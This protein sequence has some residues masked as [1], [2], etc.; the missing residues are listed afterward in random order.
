MSTKNKK[1]KILYASAAVSAGVAL[2]LGTYA[3]SIHENK[4]QKHESQ[5]ESTF[6]ELL[7]KKSEIERLIQEFGTENVSDDFLKLYDDI[8]N[9]LESGAVSVDDVFD[10]VNRSEYLIGFEKVKF[11]INNDNP[12]DQAVENLKELFSEPSIKKSAS[13]LIDNY[14]EQIKN[15]QTKEEKNAL[16]D[17][18]KNKLEGLYNEQ[19]L[20]DSNLKKT[21]IRANNILNDKNLAIS[22]DLRNQINSLIDNIN[23]SNNLDANTSEILANRLN[24]LIDKAIVENNKNILEDEK[25]HNKANLALENLKTQNL[26]QST[27]DKIAQQINDLLN[28]TNKAPSD[29]NYFLDYDL[30]NKKLDSII[31][32][33]TEYDKPISELK[34]QLDANLNNLF[35]FKKNEDALKNK[36]NQLVEELSLKSYD[37]KDELIQANNKL[38]DAKNKVLALRNEFEKTNEY[39]DGLIK[40]GVVPNDFKQELEQL[41]NSLSPEES[42]ILNLD[43]TVNKLEEKLAKFKANLS[44]QA[45]LKGE[46]NDSIKDIDDLIQNGFNVDSEVANALKQKL[47]ELKQISPKNEDEYKEMFDKFNQLSNEL[48]DLHKKE[49]ADLVNENKKYINKDYLDEETRKRLNSLIM[50]SEPLANPESSAVLSQI[51]PKEELLREL[52]KNNQKFENRFE[53]GNNIDGL[54]NDSIDKFDNSKIDGDIKNNVDKFFNDLKEQVNSINEN[55]KLTNDQKL[56][57][58]KELMDKAEKA[59]ENAEKLQDYTKIAKDSIDVTEELD[60]ILRQALKNAAKDIENTILSNKDKVLE[61]DSLD[62]DSMNSELQEKVKEYKELKNAIVGNRLF[63]DT[64]NKIN[65]EFVNDRE[66]DQDTPMQIALKYKLNEIKEKLDNP[67][68]TE[69]EKNALTQDMITLRDNISTAHELEVSNN[70]L[71]SDI[72]NSEYYDF[73]DHKPQDLID[74]ATE[75]TKLVDELIKSEQTNPDYI[76]S[77]SEG[78]SN[79]L[80]DKLDEVKELGDKFNKEVARNNLINTVENIKTNVSQLTGEPYDT[81]NASIKNLIDISTQYTDPSTT[82]T[83]EEINDFNFKVQGNIELAQTLNNAQQQIKNLEDADRDFILNKIKEVALANTINPEDDFATI[84]EKTKKVRDAITQI[85]N[86]IKTEE[87]LKELDKVFPKPGSV[88]ERLIYSEEQSKYHEIYEKLKQKYEDIVNDDTIPNKNSELIGLVTEINKVKNEA[89]LAKKELDTNYNNQVQFIKSEFDKYK[90]NALKNNVN[91]LNLNKLEEEFNK[92]IDNSNKTTTSIQDLID[93]RAKIRLEYAKDEIETSKKTVEDFMKQ[94]FSESETVSEIKDQYQN[95][96]QETIDAIYAQVTSKEDATTEDYL[97]AKKL[98]DQAMKYAENTQRVLERINELDEDAKKP[99]EDRKYSITS[100]PLKD[101]MGKNQISF[102]PNT[103]FEESLNDSIDKTNNIEKALNESFTFDELKNSLLDKI[104]EFKDT[105][106]ANITSDQDDPKFKEA[107]LETINKIKEKADQVKY[108]QINSDSSDLQKAKDEL[109]KVEEELRQLKTNYDIIQ[110]ASNSARVAKDEIDEIAKLNPVSDIQNKF[111]EKLESLVEL[112]RGAYDGQDINSEKINKIT[113]EINN[114]VTIL[115][116]IKDFD[117]K[118]NALTTKINNNLKLS[119]IEVTNSTDYIKNQLVLNSEDA[120]QR[121][122]SYKDSLRTNMNQ[123]GNNLDNI[124]ITS[125]SQLNRSLSAFTSLIDLE[126]K[127]IQEYKEIKAKIDTASNDN[128]KKIHEWSYKYL[129]DSII[130]SALIE[131]TDNETVFNVNLNVLATEEKTK[132]RIYNDRIE[133]F[134]NVLNA[135]EETLKKFQVTGKDTEL[136]NELKAALEKEYNRILELM[137]FNGT[138]DTDKDPEVKD[139]SNYAFNQSV[140]N[141]A[142]N[143]LVYSLNRKQEIDLVHIQVD[144]YINGVETINEKVNKE[145]GE[146][147]TLINNSQYN[148]LPIISEFIND[149]KRLVEVIKGTWVKDVSPTSITSKK[150]A[151]ENYV[152]RIDLL[153]AYAKN[154]IDLE[155]S[156]TDGTFTAEEAAPLQKI[157]SNLESEIRNITGNKSRSFY[158][159]LKEKYLDGTTESSLKKAKTNTLRLKKEIQNAETV[160]TKYEEYKTT[161]NFTESTDMI[162][163][164]EKLNQIITTAKANIININGRNEKEKESSIFAISDSAFGIISELQDKKLTEAKQILRD[165]K[166]IGDFMSAEYN[167]AIQ[168]SGPK[169]DNFDAVAIDALDKLTVASLSDFDWINNTNDLMTKAKEIIKKQKQAMFDFEKNKIVESINKSTLYRDLFKNGIDTTYTA[170]KLRSIAGITYLQ[171]NN[172]DAALNEIGGTKVNIQDSD[173]DFEDEQYKSHIYNDI[174]SKKIKLDNAYNSIKTT[175]KITLNDTKIA[176]EKFNNQL[177]TNASANEAKTIKDYMDEE[178]K[179]TNQALKKLISDYSQKIGAFTQDDTLV[180]LEE[181]KSKDYNDVFNTYKKFLVKLIDTKASYEQVLF[182]DKDNSIKKL[183]N[184]Y[185]NARKELTFLLQTIGSSQYASPILNNTEDKPFFKIIQNYNDKYNSIK[186]I[187]DAFNAQIAEN[188]KI[189]ISEATYYL[190]SS[191][192]AA[193]K[194]RDWLN[195]KTNFETFF[196]ELNSLVDK[197][198]PASYRYVYSEIK[199]GNVVEN[200]KKDFNEAANARKTTISVDGENKEALLLNTEEKLLNYFNVYSI[201]KSKSDLI[202]NTNNIKV[203]IYKNEPT[204][205][206]FDTV[207]QSDT[208]YKNIKYNLAIVFDNSVVQNSFFNDVPSMIYTYKNVQTQF[209]TLEYGVIL[210]EQIPFKHNVV[211]NQGQTERPADVTQRVFWFEEAG[212]TLSNALSKLIDAFYIKNDK[213]KVYTIAD[214]SET[215]TVQYTPEKSVEIP[216]GKYTD[217]KGLYFVASLKNSITIGGKKYYSDPDVKLSFIS[218]YSF[219]DHGDIAWIPVTI[220]IPVFGEEENGQRTIALLSMKFQFEPI[221]TD[222]PYTK[223]F[224][225]FSRWGTFTQFSIL[226]EQ[227]TYGINGGKIQT[228]ATKDQKNEAVLKFADAFLMENAVKDSV[229]LSTTNYTTT[230]VGADYGI[231]ENSKYHP[232][233]VYDQFQIIIKLNKALGE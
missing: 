152:L 163:L 59:K 211:V 4:F 203:Y 24:E 85:S 13:E 145:N 78:I 219:D 94:K 9:K 164:Y 186:N 107:I 73:A 178:V 127:V 177:T 232:K 86:E 23:N 176:F 30:L 202:F 70:T 143:L 65:Y 170:E 166:R 81:I 75:L 139:K 190:S 84:Q 33:A 17:E 50:Q 154:K 95:N 40:D 61:L 8:C 197:N 72:E 137:G 42:E 218:T 151:L 102:D 6:Q 69:E 60:P 36:F 47:E 82:K 196:L 113:T 74:K 76:T 119:E 214:F 96:I 220:S 212:W 91:P 90:E 105:T 189:T 150:E 92:L 225:A 98:I 52:L 153:N 204:D 128:E 207:F 64:L 159:S 34:D 230:G 10:L 38:D 5:Q 148:T 11:E 109:A 188:S 227:N 43:Q 21:V 156:I 125:I 93:V 179:F 200:F 68:I 221:A 149:T 133:D 135:K 51:A 129:G 37:N 171:Y 62:V 161:K 48:K 67:N 35:E 54:W 185:I 231:F 15:A 210:K 12:T 122:N 132:K 229:F 100:Q 194:L 16:V 20:L 134:K 49:L 136:H 25:L 111:K 7:N 46:I 41:F 104:N 167:S 201:L 44:N 56:E 123:I 226:S 71:K 182:R 165:S 99:E 89:E 45:Q 29:E 158:D 57:Q 88:D 195:E 3:F 228:N 142:N 106:L 130:K 172:L 198:N 14:K 117:I 58:I 31:N 155:N 199:D 191:Y 22:N 39:L 110:K 101:A 160:K 19:N 77:S 120:M 223:A 140:E 118:L 193:I 157:I 208:R 114:L 66:N 144:K 146:F 168:P 175:S 180:T 216:T 63:E 87:A 121:I 112:Q 97:K 184:F 187:I 222:N 28:S 83:A 138:K 213:G 205:N 32:S 124:D 169:L 181:E 183:L 209:K 27:K 162:K 116:N 18:L 217:S 192:N 215:K 233:D 115:K 2:G 53:F 174:R 1:S 126:I 147:Q 103:N 108:D 206:W 173:S 55:P 80:K 131:T 79:K 26:D 141:Q 224:Y